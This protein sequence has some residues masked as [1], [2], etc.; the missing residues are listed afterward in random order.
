MMEND[1][2]E[3]VKNF[4]RI[5]QKMA[6]DLQ[7][8][9]NTIQPTIDLVSPLA[10]TAE[11]IINSFDFDYHNRTAQ[12]ALDM[13]NTALPDIKNYQKIIDS[14][15]KFE[16]PNIDFSIFNIP[17]LNN[18]E[19][20][21]S[22]DDED[23]KSTVSN[24]TEYAARKTYT[25]SEKEILSSAYK[26]FTFSVS[27]SP[28]EKSANNGIDIEQTDKSAKGVENVQNKLTQ[29]FPSLTD[30]DF[31]FQA[32]ASILLTWLAEYLRRLVNNEID[33]TSFIFLCGPVITILRN[34]K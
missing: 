6:S 30:P 20:D 21:T 34:K 17:N 27:Y 14:I 23:V 4:L 16:A 31:Y 3:S 1:L 12:S 9:L 32:I 28:N 22:I 15:P 13:I 24:L 19:A 18:Y 5:Q 26:S 7:P 10:T 25:D 2:P 11:S 29:K 8:F 33:I